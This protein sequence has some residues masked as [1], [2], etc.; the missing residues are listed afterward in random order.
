MRIALTYWR[1][2]FTSRL[3]LAFL[4]VVPVG[5]TVVIM[6][7]T[8]G[9]GTIA[10]AWVDQD[11]TAFTRSLQE[12]LAP[13]ARLVTMAE[14]DVWPQLIQQKV[15][16][17]VIIPEGFTEQ[18]LYGDPPQIWTRRIQDT[19]VSRPFAMALDSAVNSAVLIGQR[20]FG[21][22]D[23]FAAGWNV[24]LQGRF[25]VERS[26]A[27][28]MDI[29]GSMTSMGFLIMSMLFLSSFATMYLI[30]DKQNRIVMRILLTPISLRRF[31]IEAILSFLAV[32]LIQIVAVLSILHYG[33]GFNF[34]PRPG[35]LVLILFLFSL[36]SVSLG[37]SISNV[38][39]NVRSA[40]PIAS[41]LITP[42]CMLG[43]CF[44][45]RQVMPQFLQ[46]ISQFVPTTWAMDGAIK[47][48]S[49]AELANLRLEMAMLLLFT[50]VFLLLGSWKKPDLIR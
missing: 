30:Y 50:V 22:Q 26:A 34:G 20:A 29:G 37:V 31:M 38:V 49:G 42:M 47:V 14:E 43:G 35:L 2:I 16:F 15:Q 18:V 48:I 11:D 46:D 10:V 32:S 40:S 8:G 7:A 23:L 12:H 45:P 13:R 9:G 19:N 21:E 28:G 4:L 5:L 33:F 41:L 6:V 44:W 27:E 39:P 1:R 24:Y 17:G 25:T 3:H 36:V